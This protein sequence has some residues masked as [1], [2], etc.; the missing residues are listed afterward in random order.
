MTALQHASF[1]GNAELCRYLLE[2]GADVN[3]DKHDNK[4]TALMFAA[5]SGG[6]MD[7]SVL[8]CQ[9]GQYLYLMW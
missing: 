9:S 6:A 3:S 1:R 2:H 8:G 7:R 4:Y 5:L